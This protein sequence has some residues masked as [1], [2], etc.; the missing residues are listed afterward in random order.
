MS[1]GTEVGLGLGDT[2][3]DGDPPPT[4]SGTAARPLFGRCRFG[5]CLLWRNGR[6]SQLLLISCFFVSRLPE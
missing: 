4:E 2:V 6:P 5:S 1:L 3:L